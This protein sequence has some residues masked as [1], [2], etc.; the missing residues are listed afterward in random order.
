[1]AHSSW[2]IHELRKQAAVI[3][4]KR[5]P[6]LVIHN[7]TYLHGVLKKWIGGNIWISG[8]RIVYAGPDMPKNTDG[9]EFMDAAGKVIVPGYIEPHVHPYQ[10]YNPLK[11]ADYASRRGTT[12]F[13]SDNSVLFLSMEN[14]KAFAIL[15]QLKELPFSFYWWSR[16]DSQTQLDREEELYTHQSVGE[17]IARPD[18]LMGGELTAWPRLVAGDDQ[19]LLWM[20][21]ARDAGMKVEGHFPG[22][23]GRT[24][25]R[26]KLLG[27]DGD[28]EAMTI[29][30]VENRL[31]HGYAV[32]LRHSSIRPDLPD[33]LK[34]VLE[35]KLDVFDQLMMTTDGS[36]PSFHEDGV[37]DKC[38]RVAL[39]A[40]VKPEDAYAMATYNIARYYDMD[41][42]HGLIA[43]GRYANLNF[44]E[45][46]DN[47]VPTDVL[48]K[49]VWLRRDGK[50]TEPFKDIDWSWL[51]GFDVPYELDDGDFQFSFP[52][53][54]EMVNDVITKPYSV[55][56]DP[57]DQRLPSGQDQSFLILIDRA[58]KWRVNTLI[59]GFADEVQGFASSYSSTGDIIMIGKNSADMKLAFDRMKEIGGGLVL[60]EGGEV[61][62][63]LPLGLAGVMSD[64]PMEALME[65]EKTIKAEL[66]ARGYKHGDAVYTLLFLM[67][68]HLPYVRITQKGIYDVMN[69]KVLFPALMR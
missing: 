15:D 30:E 36:T 60:A 1:M 19:M 51:G 34:G 5:A 31:L 67:S 17:W 43:T 61:V 46:I 8:D 37:M 11:F 62:S 22:A 40:G 52:F 7:A 54:I 28:H 10:L 3:D 33:L 64:K 12:T 21:Q 23:S 14:W 49:G 55:D 4:G 41:D 56:V 25:A 6:E 45:S 2:K 65:D 53:G 24:L 59:K 68:T 26:L 58:G 50:D 9:T 20:Q 16:F 39:E 63:E 35:R 47:P 69:R 27:A 18:V 48:S 13:I 38:I 57:S 32:T 66:R 44:L 42:L 29:D